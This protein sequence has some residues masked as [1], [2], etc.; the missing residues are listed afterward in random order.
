MQNHQTPEGLD[1]SIK[2]VN[3]GRLDGNFTVVEN[4]DNAKFAV[5]Y[6]IGGNAIECSMQDILDKKLRPAPVVEHA[7]VEKEMIW[8]DDHIPKR[9][10]SGRVYDA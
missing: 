5:A 9:T 3:G 2:Q 10:R 4:C 8:T 1:V 7:P 6:D